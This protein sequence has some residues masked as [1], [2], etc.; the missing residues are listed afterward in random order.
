MKLQGRTKRSLTEKDKSLCIAFME[1]TESYDEFAEKHD[2]TKAQLR[3][4]ISRYQAETTPD[5]ETDTA[6]DLTVYEIALSQDSLLM[7]T[8]QEHMEIIRRLTSEIADSYAFSK[9]V[10]VFASEDYRIPEEMQKRKNPIT[11]M[12]DYDLLQTRSAECCKKNVVYAILPSSKAHL[13]TGMKQ[14]SVNEETK[15]K[16]LN[17]I[18]A[19]WKNDYLEVSEV[20][21]PEGEVSG[22]INPAVSSMMLSVQG[23]M[24][25]SLEKEPKDNQV[26]AFCRFYAETDNRK[27][28]V[29]TLQTA[30][31]MLDNMG[32]QTRKK[33]RDSFERYLDIHYMNNKKDAFISS[34]TRK[35]ERTEDRID[36]SYTE[37][38]P[39]DKFCRVV[40]RFSPLVR[41]TWHGKEEWPENNY[42]YG[43]DMHQRTP[44]IYNRKYYDMMFAVGE[45][46]RKFIQNE[47][48]QALPAED[49]EFV[50]VGETYPE[51]L[52]IIQNLYGRRFDMT[53]VYLVINHSC[54]GPV[55]NPF[56][57]RYVSRRNTDGYKL[58][59]EKPHIPR[60]AVSL[61]ETLT[62]KELS[63]ESVLKIEAAEEKAYIPYIEAAKAT[64][65]HEVFTVSGR[66][67]TEE[68][69]ADTIDFFEPSLSPT[70]MDVYHILLEEADKPVPAAE[71]N[72]PE[73]L[74]NELQKCYPDVTSPDIA[75]AFQVLRNGLLSKSAGATGVTEEMQQVLDVLEQVCKENMY[76]GRK[77]TISYHEKFLYIGFENTNSSINRTVQQMLFERFLAVKADINH[78]A[79][80]QIYL[81]LQTRLLRIPTVTKFISHNQ[82]VSG[83]YTA[84]WTDKLQTKEEMELFSS[85]VLPITKVV[86]RNADG[87]FAFPEEW[88]NQCS[89]R[90]KIQEFSETY[91]DTSMGIMITCDGN[92][93][94]L[95][96]FLTKEWM[97]NMTA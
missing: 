34:E 23:M 7:P 87:K 83:L 2:M 71:D 91:K 93:I 68:H 12:K 31:C 50:M 44:V 26:S 35:R 16:I 72:Q 95:D 41:N 81:Y 19:V 15:K 56:D 6:Q 38:I 32:I 90:K 39:S 63:K 17:R 20:T 4:L 1:G 25:L 8:E 11:L 77:T 88:I 61:I 46:S 78:L 22:L 73:Y 97:L 76:F 85:A 58:F 92:Q 51:E 82:R 80:K 75:N 47:M 28:A 64:V 14:C 36:F 54:K 65:K 66:N 59:D 3:Y 89:Y 40:S 74:L 27:T 79:P 52:S 48:L 43:M 53:E 96:F 21:V 55:L 37:Q 30:Y 13:R 42:Y 18:H 67:G 60:V 57:F 29:R 86:F 94:P 45:H 24:F 33:L 70:L 9:M 62:G 84:F 10:L 49:K 69:E 5:E